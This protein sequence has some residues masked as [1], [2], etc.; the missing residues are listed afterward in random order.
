MNNGPSHGFLFDGANY[1]TIDV[2]DAT[3]TYFN[4]IFGNQAVGYYT[5]ADG[6]AHGFIANSIP[7]PSS[8]SLLLAGVSVLLARRRV[9]Q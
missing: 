3:N 7:E 9:K 4:D 5:T 2:P 1:F 8:F 6:M